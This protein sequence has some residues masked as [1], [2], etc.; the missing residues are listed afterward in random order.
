MRNIFLEKRYLNRRGENC[1]KPFPEKS[2]LNMSLQLHSEILYRLLLLCVRME[3][4]QVA[5]EVR[6]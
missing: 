5:L 2:K 4:Y 6:S 1:F 3:D